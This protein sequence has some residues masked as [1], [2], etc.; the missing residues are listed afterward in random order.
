MF[1]QHLRWVIIYSCLP[2]HLRDIAGNML[3][4][5]SVAANNAT[6]LFILSPPTMSQYDSDLRAVLARFHDHEDTNMRKDI[7]KAL[8]D[9]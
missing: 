1:H 9:N 8:S 6:G 7:L 5:R 2:R 3:A 4:S